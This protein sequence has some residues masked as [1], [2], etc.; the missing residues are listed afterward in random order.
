MWVLV[1]V[2]VLATWAIVAAI[3]SA[4]ENITRKL[5]NTRTPDNDN[6]SKY[7][8]EDFRITLAQI[9]ELLSIS[10]PQCGDKPLFHCPVA[11]QRVWLEEHIAEHKSGKPER[12]TL[13]DIVAER[14]AEEE[15]KH[16]EF[17]ASHQHLFTP[18]RGE[19][20]EKKDE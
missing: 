14:H 3:N 20:E 10:C 18:D 11:E 5:H 12:R 13:D 6:I 8:L 15:R 7:D 9:E 19:E 16:K 17:E 1:I 4:T 2:V